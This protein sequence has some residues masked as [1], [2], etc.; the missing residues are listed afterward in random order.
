MNKKMVLSINEQINREF[1]AAYLYLALSAQ[2]ENKN[3]KGM[4]KWMRLQ[5]KEET[6]HAM[7]F[8]DFLYE[9]GEE[10][11]LQQIEKPNPVINAPV[12]AFKASLGHEQKVTKWINDLVD[13]SIELK[14]HATTSFLK[15]YVDE[16]V[17]EELNATDIISQ[18]KMIGDNSA[19]LFLFDKEL[20]KRE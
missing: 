13:L 16:Q 10:V 11:V 1:Y 19:A 17:E 9:R 14:D 12:D 20:G 3:L 5:A 8:F 6:G 2:F 7:K 18:L 4:A 15:W